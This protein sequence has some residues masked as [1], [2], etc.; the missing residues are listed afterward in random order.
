MFYGELKTYLFP[1]IKFI[2]VHCGANNLDYNNPIDIAKGI[3]NIGKSLLE[4][5]PK[6]NIT[7]TGMLP[8]DRYKSKRRKKSCKINSYLNSS[9]KTEKNVLYMD[10]G[11]GWI[12]NN[13]ILDKSL[14]HKDHL[15]LTENGNAK[16]ASKISDTIRNFN[17]LKLN[18]Q[19]TLC[20]H[21][22]STTPP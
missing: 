15:D 10:Q 17:Q 16:F 22:P 6:T 14:S 5:A 7:L 21:S 3:L 1:S 19:L 4:K 11:S 13:Y 9:C 2:V 8:R 12:L 18:F 20:C